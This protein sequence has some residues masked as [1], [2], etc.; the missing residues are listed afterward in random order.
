MSTV[1]NTLKHWKTQ[2]QIEDKEARLDS[3]I[4]LMLSICELMSFVSFVYNR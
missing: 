4:K 3:K 1:V 2:L